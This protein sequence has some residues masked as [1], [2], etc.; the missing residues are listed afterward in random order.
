MTEFPTTAD[1]TAADRLAEFTDHWHTLDRDE[2]LEAFHG[3]DSV[4]AGDF[5]LSLETSE[6]AALFTELTAQE[7]RVWL[8]LL[9]GD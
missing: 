6:R 2:R 7:Q 1:P 9:P 3:L 8:R 4:R 5:F